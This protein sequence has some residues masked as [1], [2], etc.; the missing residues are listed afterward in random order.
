MA[1]YT[2]AVGAGAA[3]AAAATW[4]ETNRAEST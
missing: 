1:I 3:A 2:V 4:R